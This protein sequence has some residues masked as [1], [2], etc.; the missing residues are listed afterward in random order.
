MLNGAMREL[1][2]VDFSQSG[3]DELSVRELNCKPFGEPVRIAIQ[4]D[5]NL[6]G[7]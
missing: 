6:Y 1:K 3:Y 2:E 5:T 7:E 4:F